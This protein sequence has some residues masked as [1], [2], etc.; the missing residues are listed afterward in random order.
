MLQVTLRGYSHDEDPFCRITRE[1]S[2]EPLPAHLTGK[3]QNRKS[4]F[5]NKSFHG[6]C[7]LYA[8]TDH[9]FKFCQTLTGE[10]KQYPPDSKVKHQLIASLSIE[11][12]GDRNTIILSLLLFGKI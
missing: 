4:E 8:S 10:P 3:V 1:I 12:M 7:V 9:A 2:Q 11:S 5:R 6:G